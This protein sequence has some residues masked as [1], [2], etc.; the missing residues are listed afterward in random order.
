MT[1]CEP[2]ARI[3]RAQRAQYNA[4]VTQAKH[5]YPTLDTDAFS[6]FLKTSL[7][8]VVRAV[9]TVLPERVQTVVP[10]AYD[11]ALQL[12]GQA[13]AGP[14]A[15]S[16]WVD[17]VW[18]EVIPHYSG[19]VAENPT[20]VLGTLTNAALNLEKIPNVRLEQWL[21]EMGRL[22]HYVD[23]IPKLRAL[24]QILAWRAGLA[25][26]REAAIAAAIQ[27]PEAMALAAVG[28]EGDSS[29]LLVKNQ[30]L[31]DCWWSPEKGKTDV[32]KQ[33]VPVGQFTGFGGIFK[34]P[35]QVRASDQG[36]FVKSADRYSFL[37]A[38]IYG[39]ILHPASAEEFQQAS[40]GAVSFTPLL[41]G[42]QLTLKCNEII[43]NLPE[44][45]LALAYNDHTVAVTSPYTHAIWL[46]PLQ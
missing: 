41:R 1:L 39:A 17:R 30:L 14:G 10:I 18:Q 44:K 40:T 29:W 45:N 46:F 12:V 32:A 15:R 43:L 6:V 13:L 9:D 24:G 23:N 4:R 28:A 7:D 27:L 20:P 34:A 21:Q 22:A 33:G 35:P 26:F 11:I 37:L 36:F 25:Y 5:R 42:V 19:L 2:F 3:L 31:A 8:S 38:D 16:Q